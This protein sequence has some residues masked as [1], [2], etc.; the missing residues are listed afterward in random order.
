MDERRHLVNNHTDVDGATTE[1]IELCEVNKNTESNKMIFQNIYKTL[2]NI[3]KSGKEDREKLKWR[4]LWINI[5]MCLDKICFTLYI[6]MF[7]VNIAI[8]VIE[9]VI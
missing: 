4:Q 3:E 7:P 6:I 8:I 9:V 1:N 5:A 2:L